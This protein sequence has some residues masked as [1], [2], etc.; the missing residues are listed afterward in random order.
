MRKMT[1]RERFAYLV[2]E[3]KAVCENACKSDYGQEILIN[4][5]D[6]ARKEISQHALALASASVPS[7]LAGSVRIQNPAAP[8]PGR[9]QQRRI[10]NAG[11]KQ[12]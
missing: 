3:S 2:S 11:A 7:R 5:L 4:K 8:K 10:P 9:P 12:K 6:E 1:D